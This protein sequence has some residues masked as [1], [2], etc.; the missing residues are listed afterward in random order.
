MT[1]PTLNE[2]QKE[3][4]YYG[5]LTY[6]K[7]AGDLDY[8]VSA[9]LRRSEVAFRPDQTGDLYFNGVASEVD[10]ALD[11]VGLQ[12]D[13]SWH[14]GDKHTLRGGGSL[15]VEGVSADSTTTAFNLDTSGDPTHA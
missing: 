14:L 10:R 2:R 7:S 1:P 9:L 3:Q 13:G 12:A 6:Q 11:S 8:Q 15:L 5:V 4:N